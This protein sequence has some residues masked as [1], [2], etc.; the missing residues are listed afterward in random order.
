MR[1]GFFV[2]PA[3]ARYALRHVRVPAALVSGVVAPQTAD[4]HLELDIAIADGR[5]AGLAPAG[6]MD[7]GS[8]P[9]LRQASVWPTFADLHTHLDKG[10]IW[11][12]SPNP[13]GSFAGAFAAVGNDRKKNW[14][15]ADIEPRFE[16]ALRCAYAHGVS[17]IRTHLDSFSPQAEISWPVFA[18]LRDRWAGRITLQASSIVAMDPIATDDGP[19]LADLVAKTGGQLGVVTRLTGQDHVGVPA[20][21]DDYMQRVFELAEER[22]L[23]LDLHVDE[24]G[25]PT[26]RTL[27]R[28]ARMAA[29]RGFKRPILVGHCCSLSVQPDEAVEETL[30]LCAE[31]RI[32]MVSLPMCNM[33]LQGRTPARTPRWRGVT[34]LHEARAAG[35][36]VAVAGDNVRDPFYA[37]G[38]HDMLETF[39]QSVR[40]AQ[41]DHPLGDWV[42]AV[43]T[44]P[45]D[46]MK[47]PET[48][49]IAAGLPAD[50]VVLQA[51]S[52]SELLSRQQH[53]R[54]VI[55]NGR[56]IDTSLPD[57]RELDAI[58]GA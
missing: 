38:D 24:T 27:I 58:V 48:G 47:L 5:V 2:P 37:Y 6:S 55:R 51:R 46:I 14:L 35:L 16:F 53:D 10:H 8:G 54:V 11:P 9:D 57:Y 3:A 56:A 19:R 40:I 1:T 7:A 42:K 39:V 26:A 31:A 45:A 49:R 4:G 12:R 17:A 30:K 34:V 41:L 23:D 25:D 44:T 18:K 13:D 28:I 29:K 43:T 21:F 20:N 15:A 33:Y 32:D 52:F 22:G 36:R 50:L